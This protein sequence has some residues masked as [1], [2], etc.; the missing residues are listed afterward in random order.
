MTRIT[1]HSTEHR[2]IGFSITPLGDNHWRW[3]LHPPKEAWTIHKI[4]SGKLFGTF[5]EAA[6]AAKKAIDAN[7]A[8]NPN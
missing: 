5:E 6:A 8:G 2:G 1:E 7:L 4:D 3:K